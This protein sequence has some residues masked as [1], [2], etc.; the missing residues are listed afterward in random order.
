MILLVMSGL[1]ILFITKSFTRVTF[2]LKDYRKFL[3]YIIDRFSKSKNIQGSNL[4]PLNLESPMYATRLL[5][6]PLGILNIASLI[7]PRY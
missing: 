1:L 7:N 5:A 6:L 3:S 2:K 4:V